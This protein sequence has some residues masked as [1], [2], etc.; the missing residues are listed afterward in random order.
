AG[1]RGFVV[2][3]RNLREW[4]DWSLAFYPEESSWFK[5][6]E[7]ELRILK[8]SLPSPVME[9]LQPLAG[10]GFARKEVFLAELAKVLPAEELTRYQTTVANRASHYTSDGSAFHVSQLLLGRRRES[11]SDAEAARF[12][13][14][15]TYLLKHQEADGSWKTVLTQF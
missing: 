1:A 8:S 14:L 10:R 7:K 15:A 6:G 11:P 3:R 13:A 2:N 5:L 12:E 9:R 4:T